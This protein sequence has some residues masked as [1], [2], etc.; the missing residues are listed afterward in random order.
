MADVAVLP[1]YYR[2]GG[3]P[4]GLLEPMAM[5]KPFVAADTDGC[6]GTVA[7]GQNGY[8]VP[9][10]DGAALAGAIGRI[11]DEPGRLEAFGRA[12]REKAVQEFEDD[13]IVPSAFAALG[14]SPDGAPQGIRRRCEDGGWLPGVTGDCRR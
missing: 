8:L 5:G 1:S 14:I 2:E 6:R 12:S 13:L 4:R 3:Y 9:P 11:F 7:E 10:R